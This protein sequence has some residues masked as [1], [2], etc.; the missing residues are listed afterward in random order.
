MRNRGVKALVSALLIVCATAGSASAGSEG[1][2][3]TGEP[4]TQ[5]EIAAIL[6]IEG[7]EGLFPD[8]PDI[9]FQPVG[10]QPVPGEPNP[11]CGTVARS[12]GFD[13]AS[14][15][16]E[17]FSLA[18]LGEG[19]RAISPGDSGFFRFQQAFT[20]VL[21]CFRTSPSLTD[22]AISEVSLAYR[23]FGQE[24]LTESEFPGDP[25]VGMN[26]V[27]SSTAIKG[28]TVPEDELLTGASI[29]IDGAFS[30]AAINPIPTFEFW[31]P[32]GW[33]MAWVVP[34]IAEEI[35]VNSGD[36][37]ALDINAVSNQQA[38][39]TQTGEV[40]AV[41][42][43]AEQSAA[44][45][46][47]PG[48]RQ[49]LVDSRPSP[50]AAEVDDET[51]PELGDE[52]ATDDEPAPEP[53]PDNEPEFENGDDE[54]DEPVAIAA[55]TG[56]DASA[57]AATTTTTTTTADPVGNDESGGGLPAWLKF[58][59]PAGIVAFIVAL[60][61]LWRRW[62]REAKAKGAGSESGTGTTGGSGDQGGRG[63]TGSGTPPAE[64][65]ESTTE[66]PVVPGTPPQPPAWCDWELW[67]GPSKLK[68]AAPGHQS[69]C[70]YRIEIETTRA[71]DK[72]VARAYISDD[73]DGRRK[74]VGLDGTGE[75]L[76][77]DAWATTGSEPDD[78]SDLDDAGAIEGRMESDWTQLGGPAGL[79][80]DVASHLQLDETT[81][82]SVT[83]ISKCKDHQHVYD[84]KVDS[85][86]ELSAGR[87]C[88]NDAPDDHCDVLLR[89]LGN[90]GARVEGDLKLAVGSV[91]GGDTD[92]LAEDGPQRRD[93][94]DHS[95]R[96]ERSTS[97]DDSATDD[98]KEQQAFA[99]SASF[100]NEISLDAGQIVP[101]SA[102]PTTEAVVTRATGEARHELTLKGETKDR[103]CAGDA[104]GCGATQCQCEPEFELEI[105]RT[106]Q[107]L[108][109]DDRLWMLA[110][111]RDG[112]GLWTAS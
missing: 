67:F 88:T 75:A 13:G 18:A 37:G 7:W 63:D 90:G 42:G 69:C 81:E 83:L 19:V 10:T 53:Q 44:R 26:T 110:R 98:P 80:S 109:V 29:V 45:A 112:T 60:L 97:Q 91:I 55:P 87:R 49:V 73:R 107:Q 101:P 25:H 22:A 77:L 4:L 93:P 62:R 52:G 51:E 5:L 74:I 71:P 21:A 61:A 108:R 79:R 43:E 33:F 92:E 64:G 2:A 76:D 28:S 66:T 41:D 100:H 86:V 50:E 1:A 58:V 23:L 82:V 9:G 6:L 32:E 96:G 59:L 48:V 95:H 70:V 65:A 20:V 106:K 111:G 46:S 35:R 72:N 84:G 34:G 40:F 11:I 38:V 102:R 3:G 24:V 99:W 105:N 39:V 30:P 103:S 68:A 31:H 78:R 85:A 14:A 54:S 8:L 15:D 104:C 89:A 47:L 17:T 12:F 16:D 36:A 94:H 57:S 56:E 27:V